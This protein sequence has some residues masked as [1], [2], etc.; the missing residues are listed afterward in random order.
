MCEG[1]R[2]AV[3]VAFSRMKNKEVKSRRITNPDLLKLNWMEEFTGE[4]EAQN[5]PDVLPP[6]PEDAV[7]FYNSCTV[8]QVSKITWYNSHSTGT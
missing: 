7:V 4:Q 1:V 6:Q 8:T 5:E 3:N 2:E